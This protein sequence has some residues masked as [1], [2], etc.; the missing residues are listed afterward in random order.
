MLDIYVDEIAERCLYTFDFVLKDR[1]ID[2]RLTNDLQLFEQ[3]PHPKF[4]YSERHIEGV[5]QLKPA[6]LLFEENVRVHRVDSALFE[7]T[8]CL[9][10]DGVCDPFA[11]IFYILSRMEE[12]TSTA[13][14][15]LHE[16]FRPENS[17]LYRQGWL[18]QLVCE[19]WSKA[20]FNFMHAQGLTMM[21]FKP[22]P[23]TLLPTFDIDNAYAYK[24]K[25]GSRQLFSVLKDYS[26]R[27]AK[28]LEERKAVMSGQETDPYDTY[29]KIRSI[30]ERGLP[31]HLFWLL[32]DY[33]KF[34]KNIAYNEPRHRKLIHQMA[35]CC[36]IGI[37]PS[38]KSNG[39]NEKLKLEMDRLADILNR[40][41]KHSRQHFL[42]L[43]LPGTYKRLL[44]AG[45]EHDYTMGYA[46][47]VGFRAGTSRPFKWF[48]LQ[49]N[50][51]TDLVIHPFAYMDGTLLEYKKWTPQQAC[52][53]ISS[54]YREVAEFGG[55]FSFLWHNETIGNYGKWKGWSAVLDFTLELTSNSQTKHHE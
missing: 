17:I 33:A 7:T 44:E 37:H 54:L 40:P 14:P 31:V 42:K 25:E 11:A 47:E 1:G 45:I 36:T 18:Q 55:E 30:A 39:A 13:L 9:R 32:G 48:D 53:A 19:R 22:F 12:Y 24:L 43:Q 29:A 52:D 28:R 23:T 27:D 49:K 21:D 35:G 50:Y 16:R 6:T 5:A 4:N 2:Y 38:Y 3:S 46:S 26:K 41:V 20:I 34:D 8:E 10:I 15:D 51:C